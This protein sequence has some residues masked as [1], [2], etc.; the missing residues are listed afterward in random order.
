MW[1]LIFCTVTGTES[2]TR[3][4]V[5]WGCNLF[6]EHVLISYTLVV[7]IIKMESVTFTRE[8]L[9]AL[10][11]SKSILALAKEYN[12]RVIDLR[13]ACTK[14]SVPVPARGHWSKLSWNKSSPIEPLSSWKGEQIIM[15]P[16]EAAHKSK[17]VTTNS[18]ITDSNNSTITVP[19]KL[20]NP[21]PLITALKT[22]FDSSIKEPWGKGMLYSGR[23]NLDVNV[24]RQHI[25]RALRFMDTLIKELRKI[26]FD[27]TIRNDKTY[28]SEG[29]SS[30]EIGL[31]EK[32]RREA[33]VDKWGSSKFVPTGILCFKIDNIFIRKEWED[34][35]KSLEDQLPNII[36]KIKDVHEEEK[37]RQEKSRKWHEEYENQKRKEKKLADLKEK[38]LSD[39]KSLLNVAKRWDEVIKLRNYVDE[40]EAQATSEND[41]TDE[42][43][44]WID[45]ARNKINWYD[46]FI[47]SQDVLLEEVDKATLTMKKKSS[48]Y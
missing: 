25:G 44:V 4:V 31:R 34:K 43:K 21:D 27:I 39:F 32:T 9:Y 48:Y 16:T 47:D 17:S 2:R 8:E 22:H 26:E 19:A 28:I 37:I 36:L 5:G 15:L 23:G 11:W 33:P 41:L 42:L 13:N 35:T 20:S 18:K 45:W 3:K 1:L 38:E 24:T 29:E 7:T 14:L 40:V 6:F 12:I 10:I 30:I 46:P